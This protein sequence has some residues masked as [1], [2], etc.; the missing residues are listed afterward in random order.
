MIADDTDITRE[1]LA[2]ILAAETDMKIVGEGATVHETI[3]KAHELCPD[4]LIMDLMWFKDETAGINAI[5]RLVQEVPETKVIAITVYPDLIEQAKNA[6][7]VAALNKEAVSKK[8]LVEE[9]RAV[10]ALPPSPSVVTMSAIPPVEELTKRELQVLALMAEGK[11]DREIAAE[12][13]IA[14]STAKNHVGHILGKLGVSNRAGAV[15][16]G[17]ERGLVGAN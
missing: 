12:L 3:L 14:E 10:H 9:I 8:Q 2:R 15:A 4:V 1:G 13:A 11:T 7:A 16:V 5:K 6:G 17:Y